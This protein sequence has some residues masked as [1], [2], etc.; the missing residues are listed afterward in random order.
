MKLFTAVSSTITEV[1]KPKVF[2]PEPNQ[3]SV[4][5]STTCMYIYICKYT[6]IYIYIYI[7]KQINKET[8]IHIHILSIYI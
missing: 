3:V 4:W 1:Y 5:N 2:S 7:Y 6:F 8:N